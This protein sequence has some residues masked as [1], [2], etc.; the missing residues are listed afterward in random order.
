MPDDGGVSDDEYLV[1]ELA[2]QR[3]KRDERNRVTATSPDAE[4]GP[5]RH[6]TL[7]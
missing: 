6:E 7:D 5:D 3:W 4:V 2:A 1:D